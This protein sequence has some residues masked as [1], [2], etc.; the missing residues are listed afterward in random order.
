MPTRE[1]GHVELAFVTVTLCGRL[2]LKEND[3]T[4]LLDLGAARG[5]AWGRPIPCV[6]CWFMAAS[7]WRPLAAMLGSLKNGA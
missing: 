1:N 2:R 7:P 5:V 4:W 6:A 3:E